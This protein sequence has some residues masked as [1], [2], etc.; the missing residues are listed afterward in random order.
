MD[1]VLKPADG[2]LASLMAAMCME[3]R[4]RCVGFYGVQHFRDG[5][6]IWQEFFP[7]LVV[8]VGKNAM[9][10]TYLAG[11]AWTT[12][13][14]YMGLKGTGTPL[15]AD[16]M[17]SHGSWSQLNIT[18]NRGTVTFS[19]A[20]AGSKATSSAVAH[21]ITAAGPTTVAGGYLVIGGTN[22]NTNTTGTLFS[23]GDFSSP[24]SVYASDVLNISY[25][26]SI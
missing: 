21:T 11:S 3:E 14:V 15:A 12:G 7:N 17:A 16:T 13:T 9:L 20:S 2:M 22:G 1:D 4:A 25:S 5:K 24:R 26:I 8:D 18:A 23:A 19:S 10:D 6:L